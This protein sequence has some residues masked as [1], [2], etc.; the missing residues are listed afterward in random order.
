MEFI[1]AIIAILG[2]VGLIFASL[3]IKKKAS[4]QKTTQS[5]AKVKA[6]ESKHISFKPVGCLGRSTPPPAPAYAPAA[7]QSKSTDDSLDFIT[8]AMAGYALNSLLNNGSSDSS[9]SQ[10][11]KTVANFD[12]NSSTDYSQPSSSSDSSS[13]SSWSSSSS[14]SSW[15]SSS[16]D[17]S[18]SS[19]S[20][21]SSWSSD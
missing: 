1:L 11:W 5:S 7:R 15:S 8:G 18:W 16:S 19:S 20:S 12:N 14:D 3:S 17:S 13:D 4:A 21:D 6:E 2:I 10:E 9:A